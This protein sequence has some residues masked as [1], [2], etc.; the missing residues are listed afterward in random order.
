MNKYENP[1][2]VGS[3]I[4]RIYEAVLTPNDIHQLVD[5]VRLYIDAPYAG[6]QIEN[7]HTH[8][9]GDSHLI[10]YDESS[11]NSYAENFITKDPWTIK[12]LEENKL[13]GMFSSSIKHVRDKD[14]LNT[15]FYQDWGR[16]NGVR[17]AIGSSFEINHSHMLKVSFQ[18]HS[19]H[20]YFDDH[21]EGFL[22]LLQPHLAQ[23]VQLSSVFQEQQQSN[24]AQMLLDLNRP[25]WIV[26]AD[27]EIIFHNQ[28]AQE[29]MQ[30]GHYLSSHNNQLTTKQ[31]QQQSLLTQQVKLTT[32]LPHNPKLWRGNNGSGGHEKMVLGTPSQN[33]CF[34]LT[35]LPNCQDP[36]T[37]V[38][39]ITGRKPLPKVDLIQRVHGLSQRKAQLCL[40]LMEGYSTSDA[41]QHLNIS[42]NTVRNNLAA[43]FKEL[44]V[45]NQS[46][47]VQHLFN[48]SC[49]TID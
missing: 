20:T 14:Y 40:L 23:F 35:P 31:P 34:W 16:H 41:A 21:V 36:T 9:L 26:N 15:E 1:E 32:D 3:F 11:I 4:Q 28:D 48:T 38:A 43:C 49:I 25:V 47:L 39:L 29:W 30:D 5:D 6:F 10:N 45:N 18:R 33:E 42:I 24:I 19:D 44:N 12:L 13:Y 17:Y 37:S 27:L 2:A 7:L 22:N 46:E 8:E